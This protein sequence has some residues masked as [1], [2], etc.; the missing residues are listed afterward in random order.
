[1]VE[2]GVDLCGGQRWRT[3]PGF[4]T[5]SYKI[6]TGDHLSIVMAV[7]TEAETVEVRQGEHVLS[8]RL[9]DSID[10]PYYPSPQVRMWLKFR[11]CLDVNQYLRWGSRLNTFR[12]PPPGDV[13]LN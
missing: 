11:Y 10:P 13:P 4:K 3:D 6:Q 12:A 8:F 2:T 7:D 5:N 9:Q 1:V